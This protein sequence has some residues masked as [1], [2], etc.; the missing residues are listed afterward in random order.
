MQLPKTIRAQGRSERARRYRIHMI[1]RYRPLGEKEWLSGETVNVSRS[2]VLFL[3]PRLL[4]AGMPIEFTL[5]LPR[6][7]RG[8]PGATV[9][10]RGRVVRTVRPADGEF[11]PALAARISGYRMLRSSD[12]LEMQLCEA[13]DGDSRAS[14]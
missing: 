6:E 2:G 12:L 11:F 14:A 1:L 4:D 7:G 10:C 13:P 8:E 9:L 3:V 5:R